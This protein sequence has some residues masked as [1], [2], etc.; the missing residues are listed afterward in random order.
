MIAQVTNNYHID[1][2]SK[3]FAFEGILESNHTH[4]QRERA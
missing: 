1:L 2:D 3:S 4:T